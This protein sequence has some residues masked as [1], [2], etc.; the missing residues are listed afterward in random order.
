MKIEFE[1]NPDRKEPSDLKGKPEKRNSLLQ[2]I[3]FQSLTFLTGKFFCL[4]L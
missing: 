4:F 3:P 1:Q 2:A